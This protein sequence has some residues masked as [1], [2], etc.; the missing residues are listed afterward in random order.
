MELDSHAPG[1]GVVIADARAW[2]V[3]TGVVIAPIDN[4]I[5]LCNLF[6]YRPVINEA[7][8]P[9][10]LRSVHDWLR[11]TELLHLTIFAGHY[12]TVK[13]RRS[14]YGEGS[15]ELASSFVPPPHR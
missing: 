4:Q 2:R 10:S 9:H 15:L 13:A 6:A 1:T 7:A 14:R 11:V 3:H 5:A 12:A 8:V